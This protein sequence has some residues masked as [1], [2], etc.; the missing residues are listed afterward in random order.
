MNTNIKE[1]PKCGGN[2]VKRRVP[3]HTF[4][5]KTIIKICVQ[6]A[7]IIDEIEIP[8][9]PKMKE[10]VIITH[11]PHVLQVAGI[12]LYTDTFAYHNNSLYF[13]SCVGATHD[14]ARLKQTIQSDNTK[15]SKIAHIVPRNGLKYTQRVT[16]F[17]LSL[18]PLIDGKV[19]QQQMPKLG[20]NKQHLVIRAKTKIDKNADYPFPIFAADEKQFSK[21][22]YEQLQ[23]H[24][25]IIAIPQW[26]SEIHKICIDESYLRSMSTYGNVI[27][28][29]CTPQQHILQQLLQEA[30]QGQQLPLPLE[31]NS[32]T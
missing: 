13:V 14:L 1:C 10:K 30:V 31:F 27:A 20:P 5:I 16:A 23:R 17:N 32:A 11:P 24:T 21:N 6:C 22:L 4:T 25:D 3:S 18:A 7:K 19:I 28:R 26:A 9:P 15:F 12:A 8:D 29:V 2:V